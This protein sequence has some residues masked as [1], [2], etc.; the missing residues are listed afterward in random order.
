M[1]ILEGRVAIVTGASSGIG[2]AIAISFAKEGATVVIADIAS[3][4]ETLEKIERIGGRA[5]ALECDVSSE[6]SIAK[7]V[8]AVEA[9]CSGI[10]ILV[11]NAGIYP[12]CP[13]EAMNM[14][15]WERVI[16]TNATGVF[17][18][19][20]ASIAPMKRR[21]R[22]KIINLASGTFFI[23]L[24]NAGAYAASKGAVIGFSRVL[25][26]ELGADNIQVNVITP[27]LVKTPG[28]INGGMTDEFIE[29]IIAQQ[30][31]KRMATVDDIAGAALFLASDA[32]NFM[33]GQI[34]N[35]DGGIVMH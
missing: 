21:G 16:A 19:S 5:F 30:C 26:R 35:V 7:M 27:A 2:Q 9:R 25:A 28:V 31:V 34:V 1:N 17:L 13:V 11:N 10:D 22:G 32:S 14:D 23:G 20:K 18:C 4:T 8:D 29:P 33:S 3:A 24:P 15:L 12:F 6:A